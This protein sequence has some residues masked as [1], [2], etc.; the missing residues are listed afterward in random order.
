MAKL[1]LIGI[2]FIFMLAGSGN[3]P[4][5]SPRK[6]RYVLKAENDTVWFKF[7]TYES[8]S[9]LDSSDKYD[10]TNLTMSYDLS[11]WTTVDSILVERDKRPIEI[12]LVNGPDTFYERVFF[13]PYTHLIE[14]YARYNDSTDYGFPKFEYSSPDDTNLVK[15]R[16]MYNLDSVAG[17]GGEISKIINL[18][19]WAHT[20]VVHDGTG[21]PVN[22]NP[23]N[24]INIIRQC[25]KEKRGVNCRMQ[26][27]VLNEAYLAMGFKSRH[28][29][30]M[31]YSKE[32]PDCHVTD[33]VYSE[34]LGKWLFMDATNNSYF[35]DPDSNILGFSEIRERMKSGDTL[36]INDEIN[37][38]G[39]PEDKANYMN[40]M[41][42][43]FF[44]FFCPLKSEFGYESRKDE[45]AW[46]YLYP[47]GY[48]ADSIGTIDSGKTDNGRYYDYYTDNDDY[49]WAEP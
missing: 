1:L 32:D 48:E 25:K 20:I 19:N 13:A 45:R 27:T 38:N 40:Y 17:D 15:L 18:M 33:M 37:W 39:Q 2:S 36:I 46:V 16:E 21:N 9:V 7:G 28:V 23:R 42:K 44:R 4:D 41:T 31:P 43:N 49:F 11:L 47:D 14:D 29:T 26:A 10:T 12:L 6:L 22:P 8:Y 35:M 3:N 5:T 30:C 34:T 24:A